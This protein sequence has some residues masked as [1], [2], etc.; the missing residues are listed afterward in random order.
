MPFN[1]KEDVARTSGL[2]SQSM[3]MLEGFKWGSAKTFAQCKAGALPR[4]GIELMRELMDN[5]NDNDNAA[6]PVLLYY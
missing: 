3:V 4:N 6:G 1:R 5:D 2:G